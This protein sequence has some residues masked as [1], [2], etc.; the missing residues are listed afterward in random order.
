MNP[1]LFLLRAGGVELVHVGVERGAAR[2]VLAGVGFRHGERGLRR[3]LQ[4]MQGIG[5]R[6][7]AVVRGARLVVCLLGLRAPVEKAFLPRVV[8]AR[9][10][11]IRFGL[12]HLRLRRG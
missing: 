11:Q 5:V 1:R 6:F 7:R 10:F 8:E 12:H 9:V 4:L 3:Q 2:L